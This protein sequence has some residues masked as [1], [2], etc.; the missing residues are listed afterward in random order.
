MSHPIDDPHTE[1]PTGAPRRWR[2]RQA[3]GYRGA[4]TLGVAT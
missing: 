3:P 2:R 1:P 4:I